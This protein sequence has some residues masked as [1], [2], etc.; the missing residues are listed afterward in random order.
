MLTFVINK[1]TPNR[2]IWLSSPNSGPKRYS[3]IDKKWVYP[4]DGSHIYSLLEEEFGKILGLTVV[5]KSE[6]NSNID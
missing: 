1:Q 6:P 5:F 2:Q 4:N 3:Y